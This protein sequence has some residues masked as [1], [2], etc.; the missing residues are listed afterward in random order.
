MARTVTATS[1]SSLEITGPLPPEY[2]AV[3]TPEA[4]AFLAALAQHFM[5]KRDELLAKRRDRQKLFDDGVKPDFLPETAAIR[6]GTWK[7]APIPP[8]LQDRRV[9][10]TGPVD[11]KMI[12]NALNSGARVF[13][14]DFE[15]SS[16]PTWEQ[17]VQGQINLTDAISGTI[18]YD[19]PEG[20]HYKLS[21]KTAILIVRPRGWHLNEKHVLWNSRPIAGALMDFGLFFLRNAK[22]LMAKGTGPYFYLPKMESHLEARLWNDIFNF[23]QD[24]LGIS[25]GTI[26]ATALIETLPAAFEMDEILYEL[27][28]HAGGLNC[29][30]WDYIFNYIKCFRQHPSFVLPARE[31]VTMTVHFLRSYSQL[32]I[33]TCHR[34]GIHAM[35]GMAAQIPSKDASA[36]EIAMSKVRADKLREVTDGH[37]GTWVGHPGLVPLALD[38]FNQHMK[39]PNQI[40]RTREDVHVT[41]TDLIQPPTGTISLD[42]LCRNIAVSLRYTESWLRGQGCVPLY[43]LM[44]D[45]AT[46]EIARAQIWQW[47]TYSGGKLDNGTKITAEFFRHLLD[48]DIRHL[49]Q[50]MGAS[51][52]QSRF[53][54]AARLIDVLAT[55][56]SLASFLTSEAYNLLP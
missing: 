10:I 39:T 23:S 13:M 8:D 46:A 41:A 51:Y 55:S 27:R 26:R 20:K 12:I 16:S 30:R 36:N 6:D 19:S 25:R 29:G 50:E 2:A 52:D 18:T 33:K 17:M 47:I 40:D 34:R 1:P 44:E 49:R 21:E 22:A 7:V 14:A 43:G 9:E 38:V 56:D 11:R 31:Q 42:N 53:D 48:E 4:Q 24:Y 32:L 15:D 3:W 45:A 28:D 5:A 37:D 54:E 35:G